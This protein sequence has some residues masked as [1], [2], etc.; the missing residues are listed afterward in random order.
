MPAAFL[1]DMDGLLLDTERLYLNAFEDCGVEFGLK[2]GRA[3]Q[4][5]LSLVGH[6]STEGERRMAAFLEPDIRVADFDARVMELANGRLKQQIPLRPTVRETLDRLRAGSAQM[7]VVTSTK[8]DHARCH[9]EQAGLL[10]HFQFVVGG[11][12]VSANKPDPAPYREAAARFGFDPR[13]CAAFEDSDPGVTA[14]TQAG[15]LAVQ[16]PDL[17]PEDQPFAAVGQMF[18]KTLGQAVSLAEAEMTRLRSAVVP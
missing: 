3:H 5:Y 1:F 7:A 12:E 9:L 14:A 16:V 17:R 11:D 2:A 10:D 4:L 18:A 8:G 15:C 6:S 13:H